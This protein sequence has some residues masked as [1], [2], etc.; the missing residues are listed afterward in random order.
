[1]KLS[2]DHENNFDYLR[3]LLYYAYFQRNKYF[4]GV[5]PDRLILKDNDVK[6]E[7]EQLNNTIRRL[8]YDLIK[9]EA[10]MLMRE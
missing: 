7:L 9:N 3:I 10:P 6:N 1:M 5:F 4:H 2:E 8:N